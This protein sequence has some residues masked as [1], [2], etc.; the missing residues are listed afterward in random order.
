MKKFLLKC[1]AFLEKGGIV[2]E[3]VLLIISAVSVVLS[4]IF[5]Q[6]GPALPFD[7]AWIA[8]VLCGLPIICEAI[9]GLLIRFDVK[10]DVLV[11]IAIV[12][13]VC[14]GEIFAAGEVAFI[15]QLGALL[16]DLTVRK[17]ACGHRKARKLTPV[18]QE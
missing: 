14:I 17:G 2:K 4:F 7:V 11:S 1:E 13:S 9:L 12:A 5:S 8:I 3:I 15:M 10:A 6:I 16:E 18:P